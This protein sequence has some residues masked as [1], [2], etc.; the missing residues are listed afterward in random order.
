MNRYS[1]HLAQV[2]QALAI[3]T[4]ISGS[5][6]AAIRN[7][8][9]FDNMA[10][11]ATNGVSIVED[12]IGSHDGIVRGANGMFTGSQLVFPGGTHANGGAYVDLPNGMI[13]SIETDATFE[14][15]YTINAP[16]NW[17][18]IWD[19]GVSR[20][21]GEVLGPGA[22]SGPAS[23]SFF[24]AP[25]RGTDINRQRVAMVNSSPASGHVPPIPGVVS[26][27]DII[28]DTSISQTLGEEQHVVVSYVR[29]ANGPDPGA[30]RQIAVFL[31]GFHATTLLAGAATPYQ[32]VNL[33]DV[34]NWLG[35]SNYAADHILNGSIN[36]FRI[37]D[38]AF[39]AQDVMA[40]YLRG[41]DEVP[42]PQALL[43][44]M[45]GLAAAGTIP[46]RRRRKSPQQVR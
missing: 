13:S 8:Y 28:V 26:N 17:G 44:L 23:D 27:V 43:M 45:S 46:G 12:S 21:L 19:F 34:N 4:A 32:L 11:P 29:D 39:S 6:S 37:Y 16:T 7:R 33:N 36:E 25:M 41:P 2:L 20:D 9:S 38:H 18:R 15:W 3:L 10:G 1:P 5:A 22:L 30:S 35:R 42:E 40:S 31:N 14:A 24:Y